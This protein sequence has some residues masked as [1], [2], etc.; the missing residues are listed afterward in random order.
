MRMRKL[1]HGQSVMFFAPL[2]VDRKIRDVANIGPSVAVRVPDI[3]RWVM[4]ETCED[5]LHHV[6]HWV[7]QGID[8]TR[9]EDAWSAFFSSENPA[10][11]T[12]KSSWLQ[13]E[14]RALETMYGFTSVAEGD[15]MHNTAFEVPDIRERCQLLGVSSLSDTR[16]DEEQ[17]REVNHEA[18]TERQIERPPVAEAATHQVHQHVATFIRTGIIPSSSSEFLPAFSPLSQIATAPHGYP[19]SPALLATKDYSTTI[20]SQFHSARSYMRPVNWIV[21]STTQRCTILVI[22]SPF[23][24][25]ELLPIIRRSKAVHLHQY[26]PRVTETMR[27]FDD[28]KFYCI[29]PLPPTWTPPSPELVLQLNLWAGQLYLP[30]Y[31]AYLRLCAFLGVYRRAEGSRDGNI[32]IQHDGFIV[33]R[34]GMRSSLCP[35]TT[36]P[37]PFL[38]ELFGLRRKGMSYLSTH[39]GK[40]LHARLLTEDDFDN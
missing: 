40:I 14:S 8:Y 20:R 4:L 11:G 3:L 15:L 33:R 22:L 21:S 7:Q 6:P 27:S 32:S 38:K 37:L 2:E 35:F 1:G 17:E 31:E 39:L 19:W 18:E 29:P 23:E 12:L 30:D 5:I 36:S 34:R 26:S 28:L 13:P 24:V 25:N 16:T 9:R 10:V